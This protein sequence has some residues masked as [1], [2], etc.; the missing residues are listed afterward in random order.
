M[1]KKRSKKD[2]GGG[3]AVRNKVERT[4]TGHLPVSQVTLGQRYAGTLSVM[5]IS[6]K[7]NSAVNSTPKVVP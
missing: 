6:S 1:E 3:D 4:N 2:V 5:C 7:S